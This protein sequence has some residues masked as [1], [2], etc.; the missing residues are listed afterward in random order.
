MSIINTFYIYN[1]SVL[2]KE[3]QGFK[4]RNNLKSNQQWSGN[5]QISLSKETLEA[6]FVTESVKRKIKKMEVE[7]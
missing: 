6:K 1:F 5:M 3:V 7:T 4:C 2:I